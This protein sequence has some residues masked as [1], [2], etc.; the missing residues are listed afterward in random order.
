M[1]YNRTLFQSQKIPYIV[2]KGTFE[3][4]NKPKHLGAKFHCWQMLIF[5]F[6]SSKHPHFHT[7]TDKLDTLDRYSEGVDVQHR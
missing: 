4:P 3:F 1:K 5:F 6:S 7:Q 2:L